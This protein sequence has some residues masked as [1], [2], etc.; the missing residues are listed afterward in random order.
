MERFNCLQGWNNCYGAVRVLYQ[1]PALGTL[2]EVLACS[3]MPVDMVQHV[4]LQLV[5]GVEYLHARGHIHGGISSHSCYVTQDFQAKLLYSY[6]KADTVINSPE[7][8]LNLKWLSPECLAG[9]PLEASTD[10]WSCGVIIWELLTLSIEEPHHDICAREFVAVAKNS[11]RLPELRPFPATNSTSMATLF[12][13]CCAVE[14]SARS[15]ISAVV[16]ELLDVVMGSDRWEMPR[17]RLVRIETLG[18]GQFGYV[19]KMFTAHFNAA[20]ESVAVKELKTVTSSAGELSNSIATARQEFLNECTIMKRLRHPNL[21]ALLAVCT[22]SEPLLMVLE[23]LSGGSLEDWLP[24]NGHKLDAAELLH[25]LNQVALGLRELHRNGIIHR[26]L[27]S[28]N[29]LI[30]EDLTTKIADY[31]LSRDVAAENKEYYRVRNNRAL[32]IRWM[33]P[34]VLKTRSFDRASDMYAFGVTAYEVY[35]LGEYPFDDIYED[36][37]FVKVLSSTDPLY[38][39]LGFR[40]DQIVPPNAE[41]LIKR[42]ISR[43]PD[44]RPSGDDLVKLTRPTGKS[45]IAEHHN[46]RVDGYLLVGGIADS[47]AP[48]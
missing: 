6:T 19:Y 33:A 42:C 29:V 5:Y 41:L 2:R 21:V 35:S 4:I 17:D 24:L 25:L 26:D 43:N 1:R 11:R 45:F 23:L 46:D 37:D 10:V 12:S 13:H 31:G 3:G 16:I 9:A 20:G 15:S 7:R 39:L 14:L 44:E 38:P 18:E 40:P 30:D 27:A 32:P 47:I 34:E 28:R 8:R 22:T 36:S 48:V